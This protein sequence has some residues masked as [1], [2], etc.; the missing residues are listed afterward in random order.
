MNSEN[1]PRVYFAAERTLLAWLRT[2]LAVVVLGFLVARFGLFLM[3]VRAAEP[4]A[5]QPVVSASIGVGFVLLGTA[6]IGVAGW[7]HVR[8][9]RRLNAGPEARDV[10][11]LAQSGCGVCRLAAQRRAG[12]LPACEHTVVTCQL[13]KDGAGRTRE[14]LRIRRSMPRWRL[15]QRPAT[16]A[17]GRNQKT[18][19]GAVRL[20]S[21]LRHKAIHYNDL[22]N[23]PSKTNCA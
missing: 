14:F 6:M 15:P 11:D 17:L 10:L 8:F 2:G 9:C 4:S 5:K 19:Q 22:Q 21:G 7:Q 1:D 18:G 13:L 12:R 16:S 23:R 20:L 3:V